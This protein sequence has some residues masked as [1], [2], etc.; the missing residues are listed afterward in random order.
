MEYTAWETAMHSDA[1][2]YSAEVYI[3]VIDMKWALITIRE[4]HRREICE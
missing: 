1:F 2:C 3:I 4:A